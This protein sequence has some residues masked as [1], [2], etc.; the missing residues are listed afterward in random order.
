MSPLG[1]RPIDPDRDFERVE[2]MSPLGDRL[3]EPDLE[4]GAA[5]DDLLGDGIP[6][7]GNDVKVVN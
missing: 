3:R 7:L 4:R 5:P 6:D 2:D 1:D